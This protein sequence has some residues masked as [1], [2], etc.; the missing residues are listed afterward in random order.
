MLEGSK[1]DKEAIINT[2]STRIIGL[3]F[4]QG[5]IQTIV[6]CVTQTWDAGTLTTTAFVGDPQNIRRIK[7][8][9]HDL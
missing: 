1:E 3:D 4:K 2:T 5:S 8:G 7:V 9:W 6:I